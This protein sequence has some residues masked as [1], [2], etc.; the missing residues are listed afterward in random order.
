MAT[1]TN[2]KKVLTVLAQKKHE[3]RE[4]N[5]ARESENVATPIGLAIAQE[6]IREQGIQDE[7][8]A[9][10]VVNLTH[11]WIVTNTGIALL[12]QSDKTIESLKQLLK[13]I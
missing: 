11:N 8:E 2:T 7:K 6:L 1:N 10:E 13:S 5:I 4:E 3:A 9:E 12:A